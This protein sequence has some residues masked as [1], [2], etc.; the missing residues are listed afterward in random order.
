MKV[1]ERMVVKEVTPKEAAKILNVSL[2]TIYDLI[3]SGR[4]RANEK[5]S[6]TGNRRFW[7]IPLE[8]VEKLKKEVMGHE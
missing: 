4:I 3:A 5:R 6:L 7:L 1:A 8:E 2:R